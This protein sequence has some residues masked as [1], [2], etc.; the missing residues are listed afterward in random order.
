MVTVRAE[1]TID[2]DFG[3]I[4]LAVERGMIVAVRTGK[5]PMRNIT[6]TDADETLLR[7]AAGELQEYLRGDRKK[8][9]L[10]LCL[11]GTPFQQ[12]VWQAALRVPYGTVA[13]Y[14]NIAR[15]IG[16][17]RAA[18][19]VGGALN[20]NPIHILIPCHRIIGGGGTLTGY[21][22]GLTWKRTLLRLEG[23]DV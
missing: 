14:G 20:K 23:I 10:P 6:G 19:A 9:D 12:A 5:V 2:T 16:V 17:P 21:A 18:R 11:Q 7:R 8:F 15:T 22:G 3:R 1:R 4:G 13:T